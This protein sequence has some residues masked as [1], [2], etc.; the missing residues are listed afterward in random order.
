ML[1]SQSGKISPS[2]PL[3]TVVLIECDDTGLVTFVSENVTDLLSIPSSD[4][5]HKSIRPFMSG[6]EYRK[7]LRYSAKVR[8]TL[9]PVTF[10]FILP[11]GNDLSVTLSYFPHRGYHAILVAGVNVAH[12][13]VLFRQ[14]EIIRTTLESVDDFIIILD[15]DNRFSDFYNK[16]DG[17][18]T[19]FKVGSTLSEAGF[20][21]DVLQQLIQAIAF[22][23]E[24]HTGS[25][26]NYKMHAFGGEIQ[27]MARITPRYC[28]N[29]TFDGVTIVLRNETPGVKSEEILKKSLDY[30]LTVL[31]NF[32]NPIWRCNTVKRFDYFN[33]PWVDFTGVGADEQMGTG[34][35][36]CIHPADLPLFLLEFD[37]K[38]KQKAPFS[39]QFRLIFY[40]G[41]YRW[42]KCF[43]QPVFDVKSHFNGYI[44]SCF[45]IDNIMST[46][47]MLKESESRYKTML[48]EQNDLVVRWKSDF[49]I[50]F[51]NRSFRVLFKKSY[52]ELIGFNWVNL[53]DDT[54]RENSK[55]Q[56]IEFMLSEKA[57]Y[58]E[59]E[60]SGIAANNLVYQWLNTP[61]SDQLG[62]VIEY[63]SVGRDI[64]ERIIKEK[65]NRNLL[66]QLNEKV[67]ELSLIN[68]LSGY[69]NEG[70]D[71]PTLFGNLVAD[72]REYLVTP[73]GT[74]A[75]I[76]YSGRSYHCNGPDDLSC[77][78]EISC[79][80]GDK[81]QGLL[82]V[83]LRADGSSGAE[84]EIVF[85]G[86]AKLLNMICEML[87]SYLI[88]LDTGKKLLQSEL[89]FSEL[90]ENVMDVVF[91]IESHGKI[92]NI[93]PAAHRLLGIASLSGA[94]L[95]DF[96]VP[97]ERNGIATLLE[98]VVSTKKDSFNFET[99][100]LSG[101]GNILFMHI[102][103]F[104][105]YGQ[106]TPV[107]IFGIARDMTQ[108][109]RLEQSIMK[110]VI[111]TQEDERK[112]FAEDLHDGIGPLLSGLKMYL[113]QETLEKDLTVKQHNVLRYCR[114]LVDDAI[115]Q[116][117][118]IANN[119]TPGILNDFGLRKA[120]ISH[121]AKINAIGKYQVELTTAESITSVDNDVA[122]AVFRVCSELLNNALKHAQC[123][124]VVI[125]I[126]IKASILSMIYND[127]G[128]GFDMN[129]YLT[130]GGTGTGMG[131]KS[132]FNR[133]HSLNGNVT[134]NSKPGQG[135]RV[136]IFLPLSEGT[137]SSS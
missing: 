80:F 95:W 112:R 116:T 21:E 127:N 123:D 25:R 67:M 6:T 117:R 108:Q 71:L 76:D 57:G 2:A 107:E 49:S 89:R 119:L 16:P 45:D 110:T 86:K 32:P 23:K 66:L 27:Y 137:E 113:Q 102:A 63:Q 33:K 85:Q 126:E 111:T 40:T 83:F 75:T 17:K 128:K 115:S 20:P 114:E 78:R 36:K 46:Q 1:M 19:V 13:E 29:G 38:F 91:N 42:V 68:R 53:L 93:N 65:E 103:G 105:K 60:I 134:F 124:R 104:I 70:I 5:L 135:L 24:K 26:I 73:A 79:C 72:I 87:S 133:V 59:T 56:L 81:M 34:W 51:V 3:N 58:I 90:F 61:I 28:S 52:D 129:N 106:N 88:R 4:I 10:S 99:R 30:Y 31:Q 55:R 9:V 39:I 64:T 44:G 94:N 120:L 47:K 100:F 97:S 74:F 15:R 14:N 41:E 12:E 11:K 54:H 125:N 98:K 7:I 118:S 131:I 62:N 101:E 122:L 130:S 37:K 109:R 132:I 136:S 82:K 50:T 48:R 35:H 43:C 69:I 121:V 84:Q 8:K 22:S 92:I 18:G 96:V 77:H